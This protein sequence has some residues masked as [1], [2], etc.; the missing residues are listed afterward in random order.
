MGQP[1]EL[2]NKATEAILG[3]DLEALRDLYAPDAVGVGPDVGALHGIDAIIDYNRTMVEAFSEMSYDY[4]ATFE[5]EDRAIDQGTM[6]GTHTGPLRLPDGTSIPPTGKQLRVRAIDVVRVENGRIVRHDFYYDQLEM[7][8][9]L[10][11][12]EAPAATQ[13]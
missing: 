3:N 7:L 9:Q 6:V 11:L 8:S 12:M 10:G 4:E 1:R 5:T 13:A 2:M